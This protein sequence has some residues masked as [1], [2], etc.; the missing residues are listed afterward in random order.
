MRRFARTLTLAFSAGVLGGL[1]NSL[2]LW[3]AVRYGITAFFGVSLPAPLTP[4]WLYPRVVWG[5]I[6]GL[7]FSVPLW[8]KKRL[9][10]RPVLQ[11]RPQPGAAFRDLPPAARQGDDGPRPGGMDARFRHSFQCPLGL[12]GGGVDAVDEPMKSPARSARPVLPGSTL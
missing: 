10:A 3:L 2:C 11:H 4:A 1:V 9:P 12:D 5:G 6:W 8:E 7:L